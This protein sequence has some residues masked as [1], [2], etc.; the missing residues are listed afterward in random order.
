LGKLDSPRG[1][2]GSDDGGTRGIAGAPKEWLIPLLLLRIRAGLSYGHELNGWVEEIG[3]D[4]MRAGE[5]YRTLW[6]MEQDG[7][8]LRD[9]DGSGFKAPLRRYE[10]TEAGDDQPQ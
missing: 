2:R 4:R 9:R 7:M 8:V 1:G 5:T 10:I 6:W 3:F